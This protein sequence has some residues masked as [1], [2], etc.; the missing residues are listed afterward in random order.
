MY[1]WG[2]G[3][4]IDYSRAMAAYKIA[5]EAGDALSQYHGGMMYKLGHSRTGENMQTLT[6]SIA[7]VTSSGKPRHTTP[8]P[9]A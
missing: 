2:K 8:T 9:F 3:V 1:F 5:A 7:A 4:A 6:R